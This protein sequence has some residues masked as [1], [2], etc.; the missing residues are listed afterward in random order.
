[1][2]TDFETDLASQNSQPKVRD[3]PPVLSPSDAKLLNGVGESPNRQSSGGVGRRTAILFR[4]AKN[5]AKLHR[6]KDNRLQNGENP[7]RSSSITT[8]TTVST[9]TEATTP[10]RVTVASPTVSPVIQR[11]R[12]RSASPEMQRDKTPP[13]TIATG[14]SACYE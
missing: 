10:S 12:S 6:D 1:M 14:K 5:G 13:R 7:L 8:A 2:D 4:K 9:T 3:T 11:P